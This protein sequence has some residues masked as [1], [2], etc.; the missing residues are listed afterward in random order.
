MILQESYTFLKFKESKMHF[1]LLFLP[2]Y[3]HDCLLFPFSFILNTIISE[4][5]TAQINSLSFR[6]SS[7]SHDSY[8]PMVVTASD[9]RKFK[10]WALVDDNDSQS[11]YQEGDDDWVGEKP[12]A[13]PTSMHHTA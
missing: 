11:M 13:F 7:E 6:P 10:L 8:Q 2:S 1:S 4:P 3:F 12:V 9:D 5:H